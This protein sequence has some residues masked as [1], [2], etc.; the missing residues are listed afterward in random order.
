M[1][2]FYFSLLVL[3]SITIKAQNP[4]INPSFET[5]TWADVA[6]TIE[7]PNNWN[8]LS[9]Y[10]VYKSTDAC[11]GMYSVLLTDSFYNNGLVHQMVTFTGNAPS[12]ISFCYKFDRKLGDSAYFEAAL[13]DQG[14]SGYLSVVRKGFNISTSSWTNVSLNFATFSPV[15]GTFKLAVTVVC[16]QPTEDGT[17][18][19]SKFK[20]DNINV[21]Y[22]VGI[23]EKSLLENNI[24]VYPNPTS[25]NLKI[26]LQN[27][28]D[29]KYL[30]ILD[31]TGKVLLN[32]SSY[33]N[34]EVSNLAKGV[35]ILKIKT[36]TDVVYK[37]IIKE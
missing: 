35:Y 30:E 12:G 7:Y 13:E 19:I 22:P 18:G 14:T 34:I 9:T 25:T 3:I 4:L 20:L 6:H 26:E 10:P 37:K 5:W 27:N 2:N 11:E 15:S 29:I 23:N 1:K 36:S 24:T 17:T 21:S 31:I 28:D 16:F 8:D 33:E 32:Q